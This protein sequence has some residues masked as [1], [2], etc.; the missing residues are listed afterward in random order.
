MYC[1]QCYQQ[2]FARER[3]SGPT[4][5]IIVCSG[6]MYGR[7]TPLVFISGTLTYRRYVVVF[8]KPVL[9]RF[10]HGLPG[11]VFQH[12]NAKSHAARATVN[13]LSGLVLPCPVSSS[14]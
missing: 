1:D 14:F 5:G 13:C 8:V 6:I 10:L 9:W 4:T 11:A 7:R 3:H 2:S 12:D